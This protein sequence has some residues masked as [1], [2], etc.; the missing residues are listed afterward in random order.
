MRGGGRFVEMAF[1]GGNLLLGAYLNTG[2]GKESIPVEY[3]GDEVKLGFNFHVLS[4]CS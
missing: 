4:G 1:G 2:E 3:S